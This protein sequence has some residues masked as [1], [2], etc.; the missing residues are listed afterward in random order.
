MENKCQKLSNNEIKVNF[1]RLDI[2][3]EIELKIIEKREPL[4][5]FISTNIIE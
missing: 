3:Y 2:L 1:K 4:I 5:I